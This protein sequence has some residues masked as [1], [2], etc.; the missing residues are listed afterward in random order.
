VEEQKPVAMVPRAR[1][2]RA[3]REWIQSG[4]LGQGETLPSERAL[5]VK[6]G[7]G[8]ATVRRALQVLQ[9]E[10]LILD[11]G[12]HI[13]TVM[14]TA[15]PGEG[16]MRRT[17]VLVMPDEDAFSE[18]QHTGWVGNVALGAMDEA[19]NAGL[20]VLVLELGGL[21]TEELE[22]LV[23]E[24]PMGVIAAEETGKAVIEAAARA[25]IPVVVW[26]D[27]PGVEAFDRVTSDEE[28]GAYELTKWMIG[29][30]KRRIL[31]L[32]NGSTQLYWVQ[33]RLREQIQEDQG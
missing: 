14:T 25:A 5:A 21:G 26:G 33:G 1:A 29:Q 27:G 19:R 3:L 12:G 8:R 17:M 28:T 7:V 30:G 13:R 22:Q 9:A 24:R 10:G 31:T 20:H 16:L 2:I 15:K 11:H 6:L 32:W 23:A 4:A 18:G